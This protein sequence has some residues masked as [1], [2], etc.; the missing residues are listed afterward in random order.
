MVE[1][2]LKG[3][4]ITDADVLK[5]MGSVPREKFISPALIEFAYDDNPLSIGAGQTISQ[6]Y[7]VAL[8]L[9]KLRLTKK[10]K[11]LEVGAGSGYQAA[12]LSLLSGHVYTTEII[13]ELA[14]ESAER[15]KRIGYPNVTVK[16]ADGS[17]GLAEY[18]PFDKIIAAASTRKTPKSLEDQLIEGGIM[19]LPIGGP[20]YQDLMLGVKS[21]GQ[22]E[23]HFVT[24][25]RFVPMTG[26]AQE[27]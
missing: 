21:S 7:I 22:V 18:A 15:L 1:R 9:Q 14:D 16:H 20:N 26:T 25:V 23:Y 19:I 17:L 10:D 5:A 6:P 11:V 24:S 27:L 13:K 8:M 4:D 12:A 3:R 2:H